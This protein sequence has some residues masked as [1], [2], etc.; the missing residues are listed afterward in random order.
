[1]KNVR[2]LVVLC[3]AVIVIGCQAAATSDRSAAHR[4]APNHGGIKLRRIAIRVSDFGGTDFVELLDRIDESRRAEDVAS[5][6]RSLPRLASQRD[7]QDDGPR[8]RG[9]VALTCRSPSMPGLLPTSRR[10]QR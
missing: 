5:G 10:S 7:D 4:G 3:L 8:I 6:R 9:H 2:V 1:M